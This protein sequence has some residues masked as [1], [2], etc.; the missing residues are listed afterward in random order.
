MHFCPEWQ[1][2]GNSLTTALIEKE[3]KKKSSIIENVQE[4]GV[5]WG[6]VMDSVSVPILLTWWTGVIMN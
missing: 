6:L 4:Y 3:T 1:A 2:V 5:L